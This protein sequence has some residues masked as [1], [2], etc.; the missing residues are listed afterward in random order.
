MSQ[1][2]PN[3]KF[4]RVGVVGGC[5]VEKDGKYLMVQ[6]GGPDVY[7]LWNFPAGQIDEGETIEEGAIREA[8]EESGYDVKLGEEVGLFHE[9]IDLKI[10]H[11]FK[12]EIIGGEPTPQEDEILDVKWFTFD[13]VSKLNDEKKLRAWWIFDLIQKSH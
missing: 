2:E 11:I 5:L 7:G 9:S 3:K 1:T 4:A 10:K 12:A 6:E 13:E 8:K